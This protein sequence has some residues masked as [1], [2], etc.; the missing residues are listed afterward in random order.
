LW[1]IY[2]MAGTRFQTSAETGNPPTGGKAVTRDEVLDL[3]RFDREG[4]FLRADA[5]RRDHMGDDVYLRGIV[6]F[7]NICANDCLYCGIRRSS[8]RTNR[9]RI[10]L[11]EILDVARRM[12][13]WKQSTIVLQSGEAPSLD[14]NR[15]IGEIIG[16]IK[17]ETDL[18]VTISAGNRPRDVYAYW[19]DCGMDRYLLRFETSD[20]RLFAFLHPD[21]TLEERLRCLHDLHSLGVQVG[22]GFMIGVPDETLEI[23]ADNILLCR[24]LDLDMI[25]VGPFISHPETPL[26]NMTNAYAGDPEMFFVVM[27]VLRLINP[28]SHIPATTAFDALFPHEGRDLCLRRGA[29]VFMPNNTPAQYR[30]DYQLYPNKPCVDET[31]G[32]CS[33]CVTAR[34][35]GLGR[36]IGEGPGHSRKVRGE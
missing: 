5:V 22:S 23:L 19:R 9:Y 4:L 16:R 28:D 27:A 31:G 14:E 32:Q 36:Q 24:D 18:A 29:N 7:S 12:A 8:S 15:R 20:A 13:G 17:A 3:L 33:Q 1:V 10:G 34:V 6:E 11:E 35:W 2:L 25:G 30:R 21:C 26:A